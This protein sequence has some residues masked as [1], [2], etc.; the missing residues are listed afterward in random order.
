M[1]FF[2]PVFAVAQQ[3]VKHLVLAIVEAERIPCGMLAASVAV[4]ILVVGSVEAAE[5]LDLVLDGVAVDDVHDDGDSALMG[6]V[7]KLLELFGGAEA[8]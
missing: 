5:P 1:E 6:G 4:E 8:A 2:E 3:E 7:D